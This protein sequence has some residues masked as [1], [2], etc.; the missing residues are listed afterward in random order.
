MSPGDL[1]TGRR[2]PRCGSCVCGPWQ[3]PSPVEGPLGLLGSRSRRRAEYGFRWRA[4]AR[5][6]GGRARRAAG[7]GRAVLRRNEVLARCVHARPSCGAGGGCASA[8]AWRTSH[9]AVGDLLASEVGSGAPRSSHHK[10]PQPSERHREGSAT[11][12][13]TRGVP[14]ASHLLPANRLLPLLVARQ[15]ER[16]RLRCE[17]PVGL[18]H[19][20]APSIFRQLKPIGHQSPM[21]QKIPGSGAEPQKHRLRASRGLFDHPAAWPA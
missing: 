15:L 1:G 16:E 9:V 14:P 7:G 17:P 8:R 10:W 4:C 3:D 11:N 20:D 2:G 21:P 18:A 12:N 13:E 6:D 5:R 19:A